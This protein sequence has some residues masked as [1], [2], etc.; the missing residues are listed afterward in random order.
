MMCKVSTFKRF[1]E[2]WMEWHW[3]NS[4][5]PD[6]IVFIPNKNIKLCGFTWYAA[7]EKN[8][9]E[10]RYIVR[11]DNVKVEEETI[12]WSNWED[13][14]YN[15][16]RLKSSYDVSANSK[17]CFDWCIAESLQSN[18]WIETYHGENGDQYEMVKMN[19]WACSRSRT[20]KTTKMELDY[21]QSNIEK[22]YIIYDNQHFKY[23]M[24]QYWNKTIC[25]RTWCELDLLNT[26]VFPL[27]IRCCN[28]VFD[29][30]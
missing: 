28:T 23:L 14:Y 25:L 12:T 27:W 5:E 19:T 9:Y 20:L 13:I 8:S 29:V 3:L 24:L 22:Y 15:R 1:K 11:I 16:V 10:M 17:I 30:V 6:S 4:G 7:V 2:V 26:F 21:I 18:E